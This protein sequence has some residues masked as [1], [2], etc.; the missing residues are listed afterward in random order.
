MVRIHAARNLTE[1][2]IVRDHL[3]ARGIATEV[4]NQFA[5][6]ALGEVPWTA[7]WP[8]LWVVDERDAALA[9][10]IIAEVSESDAAE[11]AWRCARCGEEVD[12]TLARCW[13]CESARPE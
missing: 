1:L 10:R 9:A 5:S 3:A 7:T 11:H 8:E 6:A 12:G 4:R 13:N 2:T